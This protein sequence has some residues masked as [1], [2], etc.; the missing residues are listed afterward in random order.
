MSCWVQPA[1]PLCMKWQAGLPGQ[2]PSCFAVF[3]RMRMPHRTYL[4]CCCNAACGSHI[5]LTVLTVCMYLM[6]C[7]HCLHL[8]SVSVLILTQCYVLISSDAFQEPWFGIEQEYTLLDPSTKWPLGWPS[9]GFPAPQGPYYCSAGTGCAIG[10][11]IVE[12]HYRMCLYAGI[13]IS[14]V[15]AEVMAS[16]WEFQ[17]GPCVG[18]DMGDSLWMARCEP[19][20]AL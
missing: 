5:S 3:P 6:P 20:R 8:D 10:R 11:D 1:R 15:N 17:V 16:Q 19:P 18:I 14:G 4:Q 9:R 12:T 7:K 2:C 13:D